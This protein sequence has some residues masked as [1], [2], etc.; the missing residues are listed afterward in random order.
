MSQNKYGINIGS[1]GNVE[2]DSGNGQPAIELSP[3]SP[4]TE[5]DFSN[6]PIV[7]ING[8][9]INFGVELFSVFA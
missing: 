5:I 3:K 7:N 6:Y 9:N 8:D 1:N 4:S 2:I